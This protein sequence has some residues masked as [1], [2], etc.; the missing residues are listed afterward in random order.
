MVDAHLYIVSAARLGSQLV[1]TRA[2]STAAVA[3]G[4]SKCDSNLVNYTGEHGCQLL[5][6][7][8]VGVLRLGI[9][10]RRSYFYL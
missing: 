8:F 5:Y 9:I 1:S 7:V 3:Y 2:E 6:A 10:K 4:N